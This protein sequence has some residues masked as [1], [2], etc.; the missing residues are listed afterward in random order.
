MQM[1]EFTQ[2]K[3]PNIHSDKLFG[4]KLKG[5]TKFNQEK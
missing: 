3:S 5:H 1:D 2:V 4:K